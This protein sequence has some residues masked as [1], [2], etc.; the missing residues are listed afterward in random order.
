MSDEEIPLSQHDQL[1]MAVAQGK[2][3][4]EWARKNGVPRRTAQRW[5]NEPDVPRQVEEWR[6]RILD[7]ALGYMAGRSMWA[8]KGIA[9]LGEAAESESVQLRARRGSFAVSSLGASRCQALFLV[10]LRPERWSVFG[11]VPKG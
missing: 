9:T 6:R 5:A 2:S 1:A 3:V 8:V 10:S 4:A 7:R 11:L